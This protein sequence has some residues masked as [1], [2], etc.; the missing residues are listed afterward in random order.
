[1]NS[2]SALSVS[3]VLSRIGASVV[4]GYVFV[5]GFMASV[6]AGLYGLGV[7]FH[8]AETLANILGLL[9]YLVVF[10]WAFATPHLMRAWSILLG[11]GAL[12]AA[13]AGLIQY[14]LI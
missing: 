5:W 10:L 8:D 11:C 2:T 6:L 7:P 3:Q 12:M 1:M 4:G 14:S 9:V 13:S